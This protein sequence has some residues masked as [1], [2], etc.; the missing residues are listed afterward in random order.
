MRIEGPPQRRADQRRWRAALGLHGNKARGRCLALAP[1]ATALRFDL[2]GSDRDG[3]LD[4]R[5]D[6]VARENAAH[7][8]RVDQRHEGVRGSVPSLRPRRTGLDRL[9]PLVRRMRP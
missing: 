6:L 3:L 5:I 1:V 4:D 7:H 9:S 8:D 2:G